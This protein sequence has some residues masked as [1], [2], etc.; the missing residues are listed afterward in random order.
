VLRI[1]RGSAAKGLSCQDIVDRMVSLDPDLTRL[2]DR[3]VTRGWV[4]RERSDQDRRVVINRIAPE[5]LALLKRLEKPMRESLQALVGHLST[6]EAT[7][8]IHLLEKSR[9]GAQR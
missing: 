6:S 1:L 9:A 4:L 5:G 3:L 2:L 8:L 7:Q